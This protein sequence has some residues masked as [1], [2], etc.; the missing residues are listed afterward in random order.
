[1]TVLMLSR[2]KEV[3]VPGTEPAQRI[4]SFRQ[5]VDVLHVLVFDSSRADWPALIRLWRE[6]KRVLSGVRGPLLITAQD[7]FE[8]G[9]VGYFLALEFHGAL[10]LQVHTD[11]YSPYFARE[12]WKNKMRVGLARFLLRRAQG[13]RVVSNRIRGSLMRK[14]LVRAER[15]VVLPVFVDYTKFTAS[16]KGHPGGQFTF[17]VI[18]R[19][20]KEKNIVLALNAFARVHRSAP[21]I[22]LV[23]VGDGPERARLQAR[24]RALGI[25]DSVTFEGQRENVAD[26][27]AMADCYLLS[28]NYEGY[29]RTIVEALASS[30]PVIM[31]DVGIA[32][33]VVQH[34]VNGLVVA[35][36]DEDAFASAVARVCDDDELRVR[37]AGNARTSVS[38]LPGKE[39]YLA[40]Y[41]QMWESCLSYGTQ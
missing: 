33:E 35:V 15:V 24:T 4:A 7:P 11:I 18:S 28:S 30:L 31:T 41:K 8:I 25:E 17:L 32:G 27:Y 40:R 3:L 19:L 6:G 38:A 36:G 5:L 22:R 16:R 34:E 23:I 37:L 10:E 21:L 29:A 12:S 2:D 20:T 13:V 14:H 39:E 9:L 26:Y 1:M